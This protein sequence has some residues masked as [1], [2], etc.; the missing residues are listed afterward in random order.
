MKHKKIQLTTFIGIL[1]LLLTNLS[2]AETIHVAV[3]A[4]F[5]NAAKEISKIFSEKTGHK[6]ILS[7]GASGLLY[8]Q[9]KESA[10]FH[11]FLSADK[12]FPKRL[13]DENFG[14]TASQF[15]YA[16][17]KLVL[18]SKKSELP[19]SD[20]I[21]KN[22]NF[23]KISIANPALAPYGSA[24]IEVMN[25]LK[26]YDT[27]RSK[28]VQ[29]NSIAQAFQFIDTDNAEIGFIAQSQIIDRKDGMSWL[30]PQNLY[31]QISQDA[32]LLKSAEKNIAAQEFL[33]FLRGETAKDIIRKYGYGS[34]NQ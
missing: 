7:Y 29:G 34:L 30:I 32:I 16:I 24:A 6:V 26:V 31:T 20:Q 19:P 12:E 21:L 15:T 1:I 14:V 28:I 2:F 13:A 17:G 10:P 27:L 9:I 5:T 23:T 22:G 3:A 4:N 11:V 8:M 25:A 18:W 33:I